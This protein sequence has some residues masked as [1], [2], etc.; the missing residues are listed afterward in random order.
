MHVYKTLLV[1]H[2]LNKTH[3]NIFNFS[4]IHFI[5]IHFQDD[6]LQVVQINCTLFKHPLSMPRLS[7][8]TNELVTR[9]IN[10]NLG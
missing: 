10:G 2:S 1:E 5:F 9:H 3:T 6:S 7:H 8:T 4:K